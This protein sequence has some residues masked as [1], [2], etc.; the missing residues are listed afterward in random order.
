M[1][2][3]LS[4]LFVA[5]LTAAGLAILPTTPASATAP[6]LPSPPPCTDTTTA[7]VEF[8]L[9]MPGPLDAHGFYAVPSTSPVGIVVFSHGSGHS[10]YSWKH[11]LTRVAAELNVITIAVDGRG[12][13][14]NGGYKADGVTPDTDGWPVEAQAEDGIAAAKRFEAACPT[15]TTIVNY[16]VSMGGNASG[17]IAASSEERSDGVTPLFDWWVDIEGV[18]NLIETY[19]EARAAAPSSALEIEAETGGPIETV[20]PA[21]FIERTNVLRVNDMKA[22]GLKGVVLVHG[23]DDGLVPN[24][25]ST[26][27]FAALNAAGIPAQFFVVT[28]K[29]DDTL[30]NDRDTTGTGYVGKPV[31]VGALGEEYNSPIAGH[32]SEMST[33]HIVGMTGFERLNAIFDGAPPECSRL[34]WVDGQL[35]GA[36]DA[37]DPAYA[38]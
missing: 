6:A 25:Q 29:D 36:P 21:P 9:D 12:L 34:Y 28:L 15:A 37:D 20:G 7:A 38:C 30:A 27:M 33:T 5:S 4:A 16:G 2:R 22:A 31:M 23:V 35:G 26:E 3:K 14:F 18:N 10:S 17:I 1:S 13:I 8:T 19:F 24:N 11:H 32:A